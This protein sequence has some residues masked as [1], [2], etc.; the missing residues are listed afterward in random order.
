M[1]TIVLPVLAG[2]E[3]SGRAWMALLAVVKDLDLD[4]AGVEPAMAVQSRPAGLPVLLLGKPPTADATEVG[5]DIMTVL[6]R[7]GR[8]LVPGPSVA[9]VMSSP[10][11]LER[12]RRAVRL[13]NMTRTGQ[14]IDPA[15]RYHLIE[16]LPEGGAMG[17]GNLVQMTP[18]HDRLVVDIE[19]SGDIKTDEPEDTEL[20]SVAVLWPP[21]SS[22]DSMTG[23]NE[24]IIHV[25][26]REALK[27]RKCLQALTD[28]MLAAPLEL[29]NCF[30]GDTEIHTPS[31]LVKLAA[32]SKT[33]VWT[34]NGWVTAEV[35][36][37]GV[38][39]IQRITF[40][41]TKSRYAGIVEHRATK[42]HRWILRDGT[43][44]TNLKVGD[45]VP[46]SLPSYPIIEE[47]IAFIHGL[48]YADGTKLHSSSRIG[49]NKFQ[50]RLCGWKATYARLFEHVTYP[51]SYEGDPQVYYR[52]ATEMKEL[53]DTADPVYLA[54]FIAGWAAFDGTLRNNARSSNTTVV[55]TTD[56]LA[57]KWL[58]ENAERGGWLVVGSG[59]Y[60]MKT[61]YVSGGFR[62]DTAITRSTVGRFW[63][64]KSIESVGEAPVY[65][66]VVPGEA[67]F[68]LQGGV[69]TGNCQFD[70]KWLNNHLKPY[71]H[72]KKLYPSFDTL[73]CHYVMFPGATGDHG[74][75]PLA[76]KLLGAPEWEKE[77]KKYTKGGAHYELIPPHLLYSYN[78][79]D[80]YWTDKI[81][82]LLHEWL[83]EAPEHVQKLYKFV[84]RT[85]RMFV[86]IEDTDNGW[87]V[88]MEMLLEL[89]KQLEPIVYKHLMKLRMTVGDPSPY[90]SVANSEQRKR[91][92]ELGKPLGPQHD[93]NPR[94]WLQIQKYLR[95]QGIPCAGTSEKAL[96]ELMAEHD[97]TGKPAKFV[98]RLFDYR[99]TDKMLTTYVNGVI[100][101]VR[102]GRTRP[103]FKLLT[104]TGRAS[105]WIHTIPRPTS[106]ELEF[107]GPYTVDPG[108]K[109]IHA[110][111]AQLELRIVAELCGDPRMIAD[112]QEDQDDFFALLLPGAFPRLFPRG[113]KDVWELKEKNPAR[114]KDLRNTQ[115]PVVHGMNYGRKAGAIAKQ[116]GMT[117]NE[118]QQF[119]NAY[120]RRFPKLTTWQNNVMEY[121]EGRKINP[122]WD[123][124]GLWTKFGRR[125][126][127][128]VITD[129]NE[130]TIKNQ[131][132]AFEPQ[133]TGSDICIDA[134]MELHENRLHLFGAR[135]V[136]S[137]HDA[138]DIIAPERH[139]QEVAKAME[140]VMRRSAAKV[141]TRV[142]FP[143][144]VK[145]GV[146]WS[147][148]SA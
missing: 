131:A 49:Y 37:F 20:I 55:V 137:H 46:A 99:H 125:F 13:W 28:I 22:F 78:A 74:L 63:T 7:E 89:R 139:A 51:A 138:L 109:L 75:K 86:D 146:R 36:K 44:T 84:L 2:Q 133:S 83:A 4:L 17:L 66:P 29:H 6:E 108:E 42:N 59:T 101:S 26:T 90:L 57:A 87:P 50:M 127:Q 96:T 3:L 72:G 31:G 30:V 107:R 77:I 112:L 25:W 65:C 134:A 34:R 18:G 115:K 61:G 11:G 147:E 144:E 80:V 10:A 43:V 70:V 92:V 141:F 132:L 45:V 81:H 62:Y 8:T 102:N 67:S 79:A 142:P 54:N 56:S 124:P 122:Y 111:Y 140:K 98:Q 14:T 130:W 40:R 32:T 88:D 60:V 129:E 12:L 52:T 118:A 35:K 136:N 120:R 126:Q 33:D 38:Q 24:A 145:T 103:R 39:P 71:L 82:D 69:Y 5:I 23:H 9:E 53:P 97:V 106:G 1:T 105:S 123:M 27:D 113:M 85:S 94:S 68:T 16:P 19:T 48:I 93:F 135:I 76:Q 148:V 110:D 121:V 15:F 58:K 41:Q 128:G 21:T 104:T 114:Y 117:F 47:S 116:F 73:L 100:D 64:V 95:A 119:C 91:Y 143:V